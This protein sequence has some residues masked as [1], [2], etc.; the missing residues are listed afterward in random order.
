M[1]H[2]YHGVLRV[3]DAADP[4]LSQ[5]WVALYSHTQGIVKRWNRISVV[6]VWKFLQCYETFRTTAQQAGSGRLSIVTSSVEAIIETQMQTD[7][8]TTATQLQ[9]LLASK[10][11]SLSLP[12]IQR[13]RS[14][15]GWTFRGSAYCQL[16]RDANKEKRLV[17]ARENLTAALTN[18]FTDVVLWTDEASVQLESHRRHC[19]RKSGC[20]PRPKPRYAC[21][22]TY[23]YTCTVGTCIS[24]AHG[25]G[26]RWY[27]FSLVP[28]LP[29]PLPLRA[30]HPTKVHVWAGIS[31]IGATKI[32]IFD[33]PMDAE[34]YA[35][36]LRTAIL[37]FL[38][39]KLPQHRLMQDSDPKH[40]SRLVRE[41]M[42][43]EQVN[44]WKTP[45]DCNPIEN[46]W[47]E[48]KEYLRREIKPQIKHALV[49]GIQEF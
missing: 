38:R 31:W 4:T 24:G 6:G 22:S 19:F 36:I 12:T 30:K 37:P 44:W 49:G 15:Q 7:D 16:I 43:T 26:L 2:S 32:A 35:D 23:V 28:F 10:G 18:G 3:R 34:G 20:Q 1:T 39:E 41:F 33:G 48:L 40:T 13:S 46:V 14:R 45:A 8:E 9:A 47:H 11:Y 21:T 27:K 29:S 25:K 17:W 5:Q 42:E